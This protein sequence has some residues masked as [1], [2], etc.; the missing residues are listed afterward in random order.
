MICR[1]DI[2][3]RLHRRM[4]EIVGTALP[5]ITG[6]HA[7]ADLIGLAHLRKDMVAAI[8]LYCE[9][10][11]GLLD[12]ARGALGSADLG[13]AERLARGCVSLREAYD[14]FRARWAHR[15]AADHWHE[16]RLSA[17]VM[18][19]QVRSHVEQAES[20]RTASLRT[21]A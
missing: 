11:Q 1:L 17:V 7:D 3:A 2:T 4:L 8:D 12:E 19:K 5:L 21:A 15:H 10:V 9:H 16:Y 14:G 13:E 20:L 6:S 18:M